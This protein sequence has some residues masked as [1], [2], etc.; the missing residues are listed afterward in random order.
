MDAL[1]TNCSRLITIAIPT[2]ISPSKHALHHLRISSTF[3]TTTHHLLHTLQHKLMLVEFPNKGSG[4][5]KTPQRKHH[6][7][8]NT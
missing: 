2:I 8:K 5:T 1:F 4:P 7:S 3:A 6:K